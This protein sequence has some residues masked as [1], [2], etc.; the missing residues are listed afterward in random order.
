MVDAGLED[1]QLRAFVAHAGFE[2]V[3]QVGE[4]L[5]RSGGSVV[6]TF[7]ALCDGVGENIREGGRSGEQRKGKS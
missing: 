3:P 4:A 6:C 2:R 5:W 7:R 1:G